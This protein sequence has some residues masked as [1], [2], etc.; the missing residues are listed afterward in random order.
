[1]VVMVILQKKYVLFGRRLD[2][3]RLLGFLLI[4]LI[5]CRCATQKK[6]GSASGI[7]QFSDSGCNF[8]GSG[9]NMQI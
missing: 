1:M 5:K 9:T 3:G 2:I 7:A 6:M 8:V 4:S